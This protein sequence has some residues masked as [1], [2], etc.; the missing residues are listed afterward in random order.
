MAKGSPKKGRSTSR[1]R[2]PKTPAVAKTPAAA[3]TPAPVAAV[4]TPTSPKNEMDFEEG[5]NVMA[6]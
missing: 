5:N 1:G 3:K 4:K 2:P 6:R